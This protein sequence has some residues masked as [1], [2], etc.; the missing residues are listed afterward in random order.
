VRVWL[1]GASQRP[2]AAM[3]T[4][5]AAEQQAQH[6]GLRLAPGPGPWLA[7][8]P[9]ASPGPLPLRFI[10]SFESMYNAEESHSRLMLVIWYLMTYTDDARQG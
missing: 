4:R 5:A 7:V 3:T 2:A 10:Y 9:R 1:G 8:T 6:L